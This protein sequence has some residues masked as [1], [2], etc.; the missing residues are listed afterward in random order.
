MRR[1]QI[2]YFTISLLYFVFLICSLVFHINAVIR[3]IIFCIFLVLYIVRVIHLL[4]MKI[5]KRVEYDEIPPPEATR[6]VNKGIRIIFAGLYAI[7]LITIILY[8]CT[9]NL[10]IGLVGY[11]TLCI[12]GIYI[13]VQ[14]IAHNKIGKK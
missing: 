14:A 10:N 4:I 7:S 1:I 9:G 13:I 3:L 5:N 2:I 12:C 11:I 6:R 8:L